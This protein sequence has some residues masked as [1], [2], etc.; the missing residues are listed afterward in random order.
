MVLRAW[1]EGF[2]FKGAD[3]RTTS[4]APSAGLA[5]GVTFG[6]L[7]AVALVLR[8]FAPIAALLVQS[9]VSRQREY[10]AD[11]TSVELTRNP[12][13]LAKALNQI[14]GEARGM[15]TANRGSQHLWFASPLGPGDD[16]G[17]HLLA[18][19]PT[20]DARIARL[21]VLNPAGV[22]EVASE[23]APAG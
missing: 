6:A 15:L 1:G 22:E 9:A 11:A 18:T 5:A 23:T 7:L 4:R 14:K 8:L 12:V 17:W 21:A 2:F 10:L 16:T 3:A 20:L 19:H 13:G